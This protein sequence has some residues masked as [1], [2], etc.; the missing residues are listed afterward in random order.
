MVDV[1]RRAAGTAALALA[2]AGCGLGDKQA[3]ADAIVDATEAAFARGTATGTLSVH[4]EVKKVPDSLGSIGG[5]NLGAAD[6]PDAAAAMF[7]QQQARPL[8]ADVV[9][10]F[11]RETAA[12]RLPGAEQPFAI[13]E[14]L[15]SFGRRYN[16]GERDARPWVRVDLEDLEEDTGGLSFTEDSPFVGGFVLNPVVLF[17]LAA[18]PLA[19][20]IE[21]GASDDVAGTPAIPFDANFDIEKVLRRTRRERYDEDRRDAIDATLD[22]LAV[23]GRTHAG[24]VWLDRDGMPRRFTIRLREEPIKRF[25]VD[26]VITLELT[27]FGEPTDIEVPGPE[28]RIEIDN[29]VQFLRSVIPRPDSAEFAT[30]LGLEPAST[31]TPATEPAPTPAPEAAP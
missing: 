27:S 9:L 5:I 31:P 6:D 26:L 18:G 13:F 16:A 3:D 25:Q 15:E 20:S 1:A 10:D 28:E 8:V 4:A 21:E 30:F 19:G 11:D 7:N 24:Q 12:L 17:D 29:V 14:G 2:L 22:V 23:K